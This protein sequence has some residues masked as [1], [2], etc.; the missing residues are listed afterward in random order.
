MRSSGDVLYSTGSYYPRFGVEITLSNFQVMAS[1]STSIIKY[2][3]R[4]GNTVYVV[5]LAAQFAELVRLN[6]SMLTFR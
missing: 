1:P 2:I 6:N 3:Y 5:Y 4:S